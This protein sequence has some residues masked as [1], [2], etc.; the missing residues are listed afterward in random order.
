MTTYDF[1]TIID[2]KHT[3][4]AKWDAASFLFGDKDVIPMWV[5]DMDFSVARP[6]TEALKAR[7]DHP[8]YGY[9]MPGAPSVR[10]AI[11]QRLRRK[12]DWEI[13]PQWI[14][15]TPGIVPTLSFVLRS[16]TS[17]GDAVIHQSPVYYP[18]WSVIEGAGC[19]I[20]RNPLRFN[21]GRYEM[22]FENLK[23]QFSPR[24]RMTPAPSR[25]RAMILCN[26]HNPVGRVWT[27]EELIR[28]GEI[29]LAHDAVMVS[30]EIHC[31]L[32]FKGFDHTP[33]ASISKAFEQRSITCMSASKTFNLAGLDTAF[34]IIP[35]EKLQNR[36]KA[37]SHHALPGGNIF[38]TVAL[39]AAFAHGDQWLEQLLDYL[40]GNLTFLTEYFKKR[41]PRIRVIRTEGTY[42][43]W[44]DCRA[45]G[46]DA[47]ALAA[48]MNQKAR[49]GLDHGI[50]FGP[51][52]AGFERINIACPRAILEKAL[53][54]IEAAVKQI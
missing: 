15:M 32:V 25:V 17:A 20:A 51:D 19:R 53:G 37:V 28:A 39:E 6:I 50:A 27:R 43:A 21:G 49:V 9:F 45:L 36:F 34:L 33:F 13:D 54:R 4:C 16:L 10:R 48:F 7:C 12:Y 11:C 18:F 23:D 31:E 3:D 22:D 35:N 1:D 44:L 2:R 8:V 52:G 26:P 5:A 40:Q 38:G 30:D 14:V 47:D 41:I 42:L 46:M 24:V 29:V